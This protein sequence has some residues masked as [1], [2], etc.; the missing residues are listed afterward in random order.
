MN[1]RIKFWFY[2]LFINIYIEVWT[3]NSTAFGHLNLT[4]NALQATVFGFYLATTYCDLGSK[5]WVVYDL[6]GEIG[7]KSLENQQ[8]PSAWKLENNLNI[9]KNWTLFSQ[10]TAKQDI[11]VNGFTVGSIFRWKLAVYPS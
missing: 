3:I 9:N 6:C 10:N 7:W 5:S 8:K 11:E 4:N 2:A 1:D